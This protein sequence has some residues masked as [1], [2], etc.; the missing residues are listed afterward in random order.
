M[1]II[2]GDIIEVVERCAVTIPEGQ[3]YPDPALLIHQVNCVGVMGGGVAKA[4]RDRWPLVY[5]A[6]KESEWVLGDIQVVLAAPRIHVC[7]LAGQ[8]DIHGSYPLTNYKALET[9]LKKI[10]EWQNHPRLRTFLP[11]LL[12]CGLGGGDWKIVLPLIEKYLPWATLVR[13]PE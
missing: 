6:Y 7:N 12:G 4:V 11:Y 10:A 13:L 8:Y 2:D 5:D 3:D 1:N 9:G